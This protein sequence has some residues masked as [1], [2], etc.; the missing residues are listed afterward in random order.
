MSKELEI[1]RLLSENI[2]KILDEEGYRYPFRHKKDLGVG[3]KGHHHHQAHKWDC[4]DCGRYYCNCTGI[5]SNAGHVKHVKIDP[6]Y[7]HDYNKLYKAGK[8]PH[9][10]ERRSARAERK[11][12]A[13]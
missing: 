2:T 13:D 7:K 8:Y 12:K 4:D 3:P 9:W 5:G 1:L 6:A 10:R 11:K